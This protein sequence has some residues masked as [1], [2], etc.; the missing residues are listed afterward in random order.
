MRVYDVEKL[1]S[2]PVKPYKSPQLD[3]GVTE[4]N[5]RI[6]QLGGHIIGL[7]DSMDP[8]FTAICFAKF[9]RLG[10]LTIENFLFER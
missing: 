9:S 5:P 2:S 10:R 6:Q 7:D 3:V 8:G 1:D 4:T